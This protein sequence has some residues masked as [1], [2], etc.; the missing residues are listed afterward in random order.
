MINGAV[1]FFDNPGAN[2]ALYRSVGGVRVFDIEN[3][4][5]PREV[6]FYVPPNPAKMMDPPIAGTS[7]SVI[8]E[9]ATAQ[10]A[11]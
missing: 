9:K 6:G 1:A 11:W 10:S 3:P 8:S 2:D 4:F 7:H 5:Q